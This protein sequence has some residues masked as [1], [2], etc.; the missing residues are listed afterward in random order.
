[1][2]SPLEVHESVDREI[3][4]PIYA[5]FG[6]RYAWL[7]DPRART[8][9]A[10]ALEAS[11]WREIGRFADGDA[12]CVAPFDAVTLSLNDLWGPTA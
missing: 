6:V 7:L 3:K 1:V 4:M 12:V 5:Q 11:A 9:E 8:L 10:N 2:R